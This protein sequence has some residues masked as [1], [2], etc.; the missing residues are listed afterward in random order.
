[1]SFIWISGAV[2]ILLGASGMF[3]LGWGRTGDWRKVSGR[4][5]FSESE[6]KWLEQS[7]EDW[8][9]EASAPNLEWWGHATVRIDWK[10]TTLLSDPIRS[11]RVKVTPRMFVSPRI[12]ANLSA[13]VILLT[14]GH[15]DHL[16]N[17][18]LEALA[19]T[20]ILIP[21]GTERFLTER[22]CQRHEIIRIN[23][24]QTIQVGSLQVIPVPAEHG[25]WRYPWQKGYFA[26]GYIIRSDQKTLYLAG[27]SARGDH[28]RDIGETFH[29]QFAI[30]PIGAYSPE[31]LLR[32]RHLNP[33]EALDA[34]AALQCEYVMPYHFGTYRLS[35]EPMDQPLTRFATEA[36]KRQQKWI[37]PVPAE[38]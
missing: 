16:D 13:D 36:E 18:T 27:D 17:P 4:S 24:G 10:G 35:L 15:M 9:D 6:E 28:F 37:L 22:V 29:P 31:F 20:R 19:P 34:A 11:S 32:K 5:R 1:M 12:E 30:I 14:H 8:E 38:E 21:E 23:L 2:L 26:C 33:E 7:Q 3:W 25:G